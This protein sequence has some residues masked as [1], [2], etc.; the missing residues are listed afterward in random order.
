MN[1]MSVIDLMRSGYDGICKFAKS[2]ILS[3]NKIKQKMK[4]FVLSNID[5]DNRLDDNTVT[6]TSVENTII[7]LMRDTYVCNLLLGCT[8]IMHLTS[9][10]GRYEKLDTDIMN[11]IEEYNNDPEFRMIL[12]ILYE[13]YRENADSNHE[14]K[15]FLERVL[16]KAIDS[17]ELGNEELSILNNDIKVL[18]YKLNNLINVQP[19]YCNRPLDDTLYERIIESM[20]DM[21]CIE[22]GMTVDDIVSVNTN[23]YNNILKLQEQ[24]SKRQ[25]GCTSNLIDLIL[26]KDTF[27]KQKKC[28]N[29]YK[30][31][32]RDKK[33]STEIISNI[34]YQLEHDMKKRVDEELENV[35]NSKPYASTA[36]IGDIRKYANDNI[37]PVTFEQS[38]VLY[39][40]FQKIKEY[41]DIDMVRDNIKLDTNN[42]GNTKHILGRLIKFNVLYDDKIIGR[43]FLDLEHSTSKPLRDPISIKLADRF[44]VSTKHSTIP[45]VVLMTNYKD[46]LNYLDVVKVFEEF[47]Y[48]LGDLCYKSNIGRINIDQNVSNYLPLVMHNIAWD[49][50]TVNMFT[51]DESVGDHIEMSRYF[52]KCSDMLIEITRG[53][54]DYAIHANDTII[55]AIRENKDKDIDF[56]TNI[57]DQFYMQ[58]MHRTFNNSKFNPTIVSTTVCD[59]PTALRS[60]YSISMTDPVAIG[61]VIDGMECSLFPLTCNRIFAYASYY[62]LKNRIK[63]PYEFMTIVLNNGTTSYKESILEFISDIDAYDL[64]ITNCLL[65]KS[66]SYN[67]D[68]DV[69]TNDTDINSDGKDIY[70]D[71][72]MS[73]TEHN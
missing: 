62:L 6:F 39:V 27:A 31:K 19:L 36:T 43:L 8:G 38:H 32:N 47:G 50:D 2:W 58:L 64:Y 28:K 13:Y 60:K 66:S 17:E 37:C 72:D 29:Y 24:W 68:I 22:N 5:D 65:L 61:H 71:Y 57:I 63:S 33:D 21:L 44:R 52:T 3:S 70:D 51:N 73:I 25:R 4:E 54:F 20:E 69:N 7:G 56:K 9:G 49:R 67:N 1:N 26:K 34:I 42:V 53:K 12:Y 23:T 55:D 16:C 14:H 35:V 10:D 48:V 59:I 11:F 46:E 41:F 40:I 45:E 30:Y 15:L 18:T